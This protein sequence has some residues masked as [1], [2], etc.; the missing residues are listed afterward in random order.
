V[1]VRQ[2]APLALAGVW[3]LG[4]AITLGLAARQWRRV[5]GLIEASE[6]AS[7][8]LKQISADLSARLGLAD[9]PDVRTSTGVETPLVTGLRRPVIVLPAAR[10]ARL[11]SHEQQMAICHEL[12]HVKRRDLVLGLV[13]AL[14]ERLFFFH[15]L[16]H[17]AA[18]E[19]A[20]CREAACDETVLTMLGAAPQEYGR[21]LLNLGITR[22]QVGLAAAGAPWSFPNLKRRLVMLSTPTTPSRISRIIAGA[23]IAVSAVALVPVQLVGRAD[24]PVPTQPAVAASV[25]Q[26]AI[27]APEAVVQPAI[28]VAEAVVADA[29]AVVADATAMVADQAAPSVAEVVG[30][31]PSDRDTF[32]LLVNDDRMV[33][34]ASSKDHLRVSKLKRDGEPMLWFRRGGQEYVVRD[35]DVIAQAEAV[36]KPIGDLGKAQGHLGAKQGAL[37][38]QQGKRGSA[39]GALGA[40]QGELGSRQGE[41]AIRQAEL[42]LRS[43]RKELSEEERQAIEK[44]HDEIEAEMEKLGE[45][46]EA[47]GEQM[48]A[49]A[50]P[51]EDLGKQ[52][53][54]LARQM[55]ELGRQ[56]GEASKRA[57]AEMDALI[58]RAL[59]DGKAE[60]VK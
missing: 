1:D 5:R 47:L 22:P 11:S 23:A 43:T 40:K 14:A 3:A 9:A 49:L 6:P 60:K 57:E 28:A 33:W 29:S 19:Y 31:G 16:A 32:M 2:A 39:M 26:P 8:G 59:A 55:E 56:M 27:A 58:D 37:G 13:P 15:P 41:L 38:A 36:W 46:M 30:D 4:F 18:R 50:K 34:H 7:S 42:S 25:A 48:E 20:L 54:P 35:R 51:M 53:E 10:F 44:Q 52:M 24:D 17:F 12:A 45:E 21:L